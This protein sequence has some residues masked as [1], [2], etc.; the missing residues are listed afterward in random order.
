MTERIFFHEGSIGKHQFH[1]MADKLGWPGTDEE[2]QRYLEAL[3]AKTT[4][5]NTDRSIGHPGAIKKIDT[6]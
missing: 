1:R 5:N 4:R 3:H 6:G 2:L